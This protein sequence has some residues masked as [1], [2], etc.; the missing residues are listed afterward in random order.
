MYT[1]NTRHITV[2]ITCQFALL[3]ELWYYVPWFIG[4]WM[5]TY[6]LVYIYMKNNTF[7]SFLVQ[8]VVLR[9]TLELMVG[10]ILESKQSWNIW[11]DKRIGGSN[12]NLQMKKSIEHFRNLGARSVI[13]VGQTVLIFW[14]SL[15]LSML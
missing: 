2:Y 11:S 9:F 7:T 10:Q 6:M 13:L 1:Y 3:L 14:Y 12:N 15:H 5:Q 8:F 4:F